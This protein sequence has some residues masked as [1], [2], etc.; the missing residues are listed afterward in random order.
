[1]G[2]EEIKVLVRLYNI[3]NGTAEEPLVISDY[4]ELK[5]FFAGNF[6]SKKIGFDLIDLSA[7]N[8]AHNESDMHIALD[9][10]I[11]ASDTQ[12]TPWVA[13]QLYG[14][15]DG[16]QHVILN[17]KAD[18]FIDTSNRHHDTHVKNIGFVD[19]DI[20]SSILSYPR[21]STFG[22]FVSGKATVPNSNHGS[23]S[24]FRVAGNTSRI[25]SNLHI[26]AT[27]PT[28]KKY[29]SISISGLF[30]APSAPLYIGSGYS[31]G[32]IRTK[33]AATDG[34]DS[35]F[36]VEIGGLTASSSM[37]MFGVSYK[38]IE[39]SQLYSA[40]SFQIP[41][42]QE[43]VSQT[44]DSRRPLFSAG[45]INGRLTYI[46]IFN[47]GSTS[48][49]IGSIDPK[50]Y[51]WRFVKDRMKSTMV[52][53][54]G[55]MHQDTNNDGQADSFGTGADYAAAGMTEAELKQASSFAGVWTHA[56][57]DFDIKDGEYPVLKNMPYP[58]EEGASWMSADDPG[59]AYQR[60]TYNDYLT[61]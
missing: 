29:S 6:E 23:F 51:S 53:S 35:R 32:A 43:I 24:P 48:D 8:K 33:L 59:V 16:K 40:M 15:L 14:T 60:A 55:N 22:V 4:D 10:D 57:S 18:G 56:D 36:G 30:A 28:Y 1:M 46:P 13:S 39:Q 44:A 27:T 41:T 49:P 42:S 50:A 47:G 20:T 17:L 58:H 31:N 12:S 7:F 26:D 11:D 3:Q 54:V 34:V 45:M 37:Q 21:G 61:P 9:R 19:V 5:S 25:Y 52:R 2:S 38:D